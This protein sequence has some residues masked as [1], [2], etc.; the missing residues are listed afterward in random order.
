MNGAANGVGSR[1]SEL[2]SLIQDGK[3]A[4]NASTVN[5]SIAD[6]QVTVSGPM[7]MRAIVQLVRYD[8]RNHD[9]AV[10]HG[11]NRGRNLPH[12]NIV[13]DLIVLGWWEG[14]ELKFPLPEMANNDLKAAI[15]V[16]K[17]RGGPII[18]ATKF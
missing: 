2:K 11:E 3:S 5:V 15:I 6:G 9:V 1:Q 7:S 17:G 4:P 10:Q 8:P 16:Q 18:G 12:K 14:G 13:Q